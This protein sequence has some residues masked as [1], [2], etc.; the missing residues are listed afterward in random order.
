MVIMYGRF[1]VRKFVWRIGMAVT[2]WARGSAPRGKCS[3]GCAGPT[4]DPR[5]GP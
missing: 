4:T 5:G 3:A 1:L 2:G